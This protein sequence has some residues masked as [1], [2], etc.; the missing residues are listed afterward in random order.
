MKRDKRHSHDRASAMFEAFIS[1]LQRFTIGALS[2][3]VA[4]NTTLVLA[5]DF[6]YH[7]PPKDVMDAL[8]APP[9]PV[10]L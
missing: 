3:C 1:V 6:P 5:D 2:F 10:L 9:T 7:Q 8:N 4:G